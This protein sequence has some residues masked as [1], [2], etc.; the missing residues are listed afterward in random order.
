MQSMLGMVPKFSPDFLQRMQ[1]GTLPAGTV[2]TGILEND[3][4]SKKSKAGDVFSIRLEDGFSI[5]GTEVI[6]K[7]SKILGSVS[8]AVASHSRKAGHPGSLT[9]ALQTLIFPDGRTTQ[10]WGFIEHNPLRNSRNQSGS[11]ISSKASGYGK[12][13]SFGTL[14]FITR[15]VG[16]NLRP[17][18]YFGQELKLDKGEVLPIRSNRPIDLTK[19]NAPIQ[20]MPMPPGTVNGVS[21]SGALPPG[22]SS[23]SPN[24][25][26]GLPPYTPVTNNYIAPANSVPGLPPGYNLQPTPIMPATASQALGQLSPSAQSPNVL[27]PSQMEPF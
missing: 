16:Y 25:A 17:A 11:N 26:P 19:M 13:A 3:L 9:I 10:F 7:Q 20:T 15:K 4:S 22:M 21:Q 14:N 6:P 23:I 1:T 2:L 24:S 5:N 18:N 27:Y 8:T 12:M